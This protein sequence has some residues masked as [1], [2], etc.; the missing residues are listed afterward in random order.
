MSWRL[1]LLLLLC[2]CPAL[3]TS[4]GLTTTQSPDQFVD[5][6]QFVCTVMPV[7][8]R[9]CSYLACHGNPD[10]ALRIYSSGKLRLTDDGTRNTRDSSLTS[11]E[12]ELNFESAAGLLYLSSAAAR[13]A[14]IISQ[15]PLLAKPLA[16]RVGGAEHHGVGVFPVY[17][18]LTLGDDTE[19][20]ALVTW[21]GGA[22]Q[23]NP[24]DTNCAAVFNNLGLM[25][26]SP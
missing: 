20:N 1:G 23:P 24:V 8:I 15:V 10:H 4:Q 6:N 18:A 13:T 25:P 14:P 12:V 5:Y 19:W 22:T 3:D 9:R 17:P 7:L 2:G 21:V 11:D 26:R 16:R